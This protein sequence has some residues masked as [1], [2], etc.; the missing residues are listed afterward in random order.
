MNMRIIKTKIQMKQKLITMKW[1]MFIKMKN[2]EK[3][4]RMHELL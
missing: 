2:L 3:L 1:M 4:D